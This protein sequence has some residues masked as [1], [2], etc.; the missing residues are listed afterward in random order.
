MPSLCLNGTSLYYEELGTGVPLVLLHGL[1]SS[2]QD[3]RLQ[4]R[5]LSDRYRVIAP[6]M[7]GH[8]RSVL[9]KT[10]YSIPQFARDVQALFDVLQLEKAHVVGLSMG[11]AIALEF[12]L[13]FPERVER[14]ILVNTLPDFTPHSLLDY[15]RVFFRF[16]LLTL[17]G[18]KGWSRFLSKRL[19]PHPE[20]KALRK[21]FVEKFSKND[22]TVYRAVQS[23]LFVWNVEARLPEIGCPVLVLASDHDYWSVERKAAYTAC[24][25]NGQL[26]VVENSA[27]AMPVDQPERFN[28]LLRG[29]LEGRL[30][31]DVKHDS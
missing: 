19:F 31:K 17:F 16:S 18:M 10:G 22:P 8:G 23:A 30:L 12:T 3:W 9:S 14:L 15:G 13:T 7:R 25:K 29:F 26:R 27:H 21:G 11:G 28:T 4:C 24:F 20:Q 2:S 1:G 6:D 5:Q